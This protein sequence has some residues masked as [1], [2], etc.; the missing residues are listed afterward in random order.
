MHAPL[1]SLGLNCATGPEFMT[2]HIRSLSALAKT[3]T[4]CYPNAGLPDDDGQY[5]E[6]P[7]SL[8]AELERFME[9]GWVNIVGGCCGTTPAHIA[10]LAAAAAG[11]K[12]RRV[13]IHN[14]TLVSGHRPARGRRRQPARPRRRAH[15][16]AR[17]PQV[18][19]AHRRGPVRGGGGDRARAGQE[20]RAGHRRLPAGPGPRR[21]GRRQRVPRAGDPH[22]Q[23]A[24]HDRLDR[25]EGDG[26]RAQVEPGQV[27]PELDQ[28]RGR[29]GALPGRRAARAA[30]RRGPRRRHD[31]RG[32]RERH[33][34]D[35]RAQARGRAPQLH[36]PDREVRVSGRGH[37]LRSARLSVRDRRRE[38]RRAARRR[39]SRGSA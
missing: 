26:A 25:R 23:G 6:T 33:G 21:D 38:V 7:A 27:D 14:K 18:Q 32:S 11:K 16:R 1:L 20:R 9:E 17:Q 8:S 10:A 5:T 19:A 36:A 12:P 29:G 22:G 35:A 39:R 31:R 34:R 3:L 15:Q 4:S 37:L 2:D 13:P 30:L 24:A 28:P